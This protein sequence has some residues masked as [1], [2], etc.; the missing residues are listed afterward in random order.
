[1]NSRWIV[2]PSVSSCYL[3]V[4]SLSS[5]SYAG[6]LQSLTTGC[7]SPGPSRGRCDWKAQQ[8]ALHSH[9]WLT[10][11]NC[12]AVLRGCRRQKCL[13]PAITLLLF[14]FS[15]PPPPSSAFQTHPMEAWE[16]DSLHSSQALQQLVLLINITSTK[17]EELNVEPAATVFLRFFGFNC[18][19]LT[20][21]D[22]KSLPRAA[23][24]QDMLKAVVI[25]K[26]GYIKG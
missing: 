1:M 23:Q 5:S 3:L 7:K 19:W 2:M 17:A 11:C 4:N 24:S 21:A 26:V 10:F 12:P 18:T 22:V 6:G 8:A 25:V 14:F 16:Y 9:R 13:C 15:P 20:S